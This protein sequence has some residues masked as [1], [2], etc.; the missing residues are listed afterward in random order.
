MA[1]TRQV[2]YGAP[3]HGYAVAVRVHKLIGVSEGLASDATFARQA[4]RKFL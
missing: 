4:R 3:G 1:L 2:I